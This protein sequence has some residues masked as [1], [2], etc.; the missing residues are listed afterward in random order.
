MLNI[1][2]KQN[3]LAYYECKWD[4]VYA[5]LGLE[6]SRCE[7][8]ASQNVLMRRTEV[9]F[10]DVVHSIQE[11]FGT[12]YQLVL[13]RTLEALLENDKKFFLMKTVY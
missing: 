2:S 3:A 1:A 12:V 4:L 5:K 6:D 9:V 13:V 10:L 8:S 11:V 7:N